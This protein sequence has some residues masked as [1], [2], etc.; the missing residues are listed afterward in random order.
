L[1]IVILIDFNFNGQDLFEISLMEVKSYFKFIIIVMEL[2]QVI[3][4]I[5]K[6]KFILKTILNWKLFLI[7]HFIIEFIFKILHLFY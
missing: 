6:M 3:N 7:N 1:V 5:I 2:F 4:I